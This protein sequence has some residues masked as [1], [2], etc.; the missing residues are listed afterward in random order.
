[1]AGHAIGYRKAE[2]YWMSRIAR[3][4]QISSAYGKPVPMPNQDG[5]RIK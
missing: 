4:A 2:K 3:K 5:K 1:M